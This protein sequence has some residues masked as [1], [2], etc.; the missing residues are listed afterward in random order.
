MKRLILHSPT[1]LVGERASKYSSQW[2][3]FTRSCQE[4]VT[5]DSM[6]STAI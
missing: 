5:N 6:A 4:N 1:E 3:A 2:A